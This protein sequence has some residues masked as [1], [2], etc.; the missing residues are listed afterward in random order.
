M[1]KTVE[2]GGDYTQALASANREKTVDVSVAEDFMIYA[3]ENDGFS[4]VTSYDNWGVSNFNPGDW[5]Y[6]ASVNLSSGYN[7]F[8]IA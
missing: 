3:W 8:A 6:F 5:I 2:V 1:A 4:G 7:S